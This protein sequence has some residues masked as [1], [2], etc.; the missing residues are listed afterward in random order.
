MHTGLNVYRET[1]GGSRFV[2]NSL[3]MCYKWSETGSTSRSNLI[4]PVTFTQVCP[5]PFK[6]TYTVDGMRLKK[7]YIQTL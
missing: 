1:S 3:L 7:P 4:F 5:I 2:T 6:T